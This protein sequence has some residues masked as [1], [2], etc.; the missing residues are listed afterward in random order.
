MLPKIYQNHIIKPKI[1][2]ISFRIRVVVQAFVAE[3]IE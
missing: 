3:N 2:L 1:L